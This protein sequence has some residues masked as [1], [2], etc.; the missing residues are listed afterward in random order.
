MLFAASKACLSVLSRVYACGLVSG[1]LLIGSWEGTKQ[2]FY[3]VDMHF[4]SKSITALSAPPPCLRENYYIARCCCSWPFLLLPLV[5]GTSRTP[6]TSASGATTEDFSDD[7]NLEI[8]DML[9][10]P[11]YLAPRA[12]PLILER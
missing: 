3:C 11:V 1:Y 8:G 6:T 7:L 12:R 2:N 9:S 5:Q 4:I 10:R